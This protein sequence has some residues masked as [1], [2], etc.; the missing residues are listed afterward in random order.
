MK[1]LSA[2]S[3]NVIELNWK[4]IFFAL[5][6]FCFITGSNLQ[7][8]SYYEITTW[9]FVLLGITDQY[10]LMFCAF[11]IYIWFNSSYFSQR[12]SLILVR[13]HRFYT[14]F[15]SNLVPVIVFTVIFA[16]SPSICAMLIGAISGLPLSGGFSESLAQDTANGAII[17]LFHLHFDSVPLAVICTALY[18]LLGLLFLAFILQYLLTVCS[19]KVSFAI[20]LVGYML[21]V[22]AVQKGIDEVFPYPFVNNYFILPHALSRN[23]IWICLIVAV[24]VVAILMFLLRKRWG[25]KNL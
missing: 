19:K 12:S 15:I 21:S 24:L 20:V 7:L 1:S 4:K 23:C 14:Y 8:A 22:F 17:Q 2:R 6:V 10:Y 3:W 25:C 5:L 9:E 18:F 16:I 13:Y 11:P